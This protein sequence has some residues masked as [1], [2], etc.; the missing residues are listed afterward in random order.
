MGCCSKS[1]IVAGCCCENIVLE[2]PPKLGCAAECMTCCLE[3]KACCAIGDAPLPCGCCGPTCACNSTLCK[4]KQTC[5]CVA[6]Q[7][8]LPC[9]DDTPIICTLLPFCAVYPKCG[10]CETL[11][12]VVKVREV[13]ASREAPAQQE[14]S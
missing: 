1:V 5:L 10:C 13:T 6:V 7:G 3:C 11:D 9:S 4:V 8:S 14:M 2:C 12:S